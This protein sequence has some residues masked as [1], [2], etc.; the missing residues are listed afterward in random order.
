MRLR[1][2]IVLAIILFLLCSCIRVDGQKQSITT[3]E[4]TQYTERSY[5]AVAY[6][7][8][9]KPDGSSIETPV[10]LTLIE[11]SM[12]TTDGQVISKA[13][14]QSRARMPAMGSIGTA[15]SA[16]GIPGS[17]LLDKFLGGAGGGSLDLFGG[18]GLTEEIV[19]A[20][21][22]AWAAER[23]Y[24][25]K[26]RR[27]PPQQNPPEHRQYRREDDVELNPPSKPAS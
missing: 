2:L 13:E 25:A 9:T 11:T 12:T 18:E 21:G 22:M 5:Q 10:I 26:R 4:K 23:V 14:S 20:A 8:V 15:M 1:K 3:E 24:A 16:M 17:S 19:T 27:M 6:N 7:K